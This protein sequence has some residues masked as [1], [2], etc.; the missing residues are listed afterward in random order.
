MKENASSHAELTSIAYLEKKRKLQ[1]EQLEIPFPKQLCRGPSWDSSKEPNKIGSDEFGKGGESDP[2]STN[3][4]SFH[5]NSD[6]FMSIDDEA[7]TDPDCPETRTSEEPST[8]SASWAGTSSGTSLYTSETQ[9]SVSTSTSEPE[10]LS[11]NELH[12]CPEHQHGRH[13]MEFGSNVDLGFSEYGR[14]E[15]TNYT[16]KELGDLLY[17]NGVGP[18]DSYI[19]SSGRW[20]VNQDADAQQEG[21]KKMTIDKEF[22]QY[23]SMLML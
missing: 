22:E 5:S 9:P 17:S 4:N 12:D 7:K 16:E 14:A 15:I 10:S 6:S 1:D 8:S 2:E 21:K 20:S 23:F 13:D 18:G 19:L 3:S 11:T